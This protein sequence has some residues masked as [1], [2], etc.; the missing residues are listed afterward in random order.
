MESGRW[1]DDVDNE[2]A[3]IANSSGSYGTRGLAQKLCGSTEN[4]Q[5]GPSW[6]V[7]GKE[8]SMSEKLKDTA[9]NSAANMACGLD[10]DG[11]ANGEQLVCALAVRD[12][13]VS[14]LYR[15]TIRRVVLGTLCDGC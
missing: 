13:F 6:M 15:Y 5:P 12:D 14:P 11:N 8:D 3:D 7:Q 2:L 1:T 10:E 9:T 4:S